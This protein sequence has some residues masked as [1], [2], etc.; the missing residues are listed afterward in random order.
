MKKKTTKK[1]KTAKTSTATKGQPG[2]YK[3]QKKD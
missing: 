3:G 2:W 1:N